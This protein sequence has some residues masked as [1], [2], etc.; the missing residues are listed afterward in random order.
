MGVNS[1]G[2]GKWHYYTSGLI[3]PLMACLFGHLLY[4]YL[5]GNVSSD[6]SQEVS[7]R[8]F[9]ALI[10]GSLVAIIAFFLMTNIKILSEG[11]KTIQAA[12]LCGLL[13]AE[14]LVFSGSKMPGMAGITL[15]LFFYYHSVEH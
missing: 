13:S 4:K 1:L 2:H 5:L 6:S 15:W 3:V 7:E 11:K 12:I 10:V 9:R 8:P 14:T